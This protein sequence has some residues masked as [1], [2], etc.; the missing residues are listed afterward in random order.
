MS[1][2]SNETSRRDALK[3]VAGTSSALVLGSSTVATAAAQS[4]G[5]GDT[6]AYTECKG[7]T[8][9][10]FRFGGRTVQMGLSVS[11]DEDPGSTSINTQFGWGINVEG[12]DKSNRIRARNI[13]VKYQ[14]TTNSSGRPRIEYGDD[15][16]AT[17]INK[18]GDVEET[19]EA[20]QILINGVFSAL[21][22]PISAPSLGGK[23]D[24]N[25]RNFQ[26]SRYEP[27]G[28]AF[29]FPETIVSEE[30]E[31]GGGAVC[32]YETVDDV[33][34]GILGGEATFTA[35][36]VL[37]MPSR[38]TDGLKEIS[39]VSKSLT[40]ENRKAWDLG[41][42]ESEEKPIWKYYDEDDNGEVGDFEI[43]AMISDYNDGDPVPGTDD[44]TITEEEM[45]TAIEKWKNN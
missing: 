26:D 40:V 37:E 12:H 18:G 42:S 22:A 29:T 32:N 30:N 43:L 27:E 45:D 41:S 5:C 44:R 13:E 14:P 17:Y 4:E 8:N 24:I 9:E 21:G 25:N 10:T 34:E 7:H 1:D 16:R 20:L 35:E 28:E 38:Q 6:R 15:K 23:N 19:R 2:R 33:S 11:G 31:A 3:L 39:T 36:L